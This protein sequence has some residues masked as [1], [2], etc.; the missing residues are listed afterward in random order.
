[1]TAFPP[2]GYCLL[3]LDL[4]GKIPNR[5][6][7]QKLKIGR[8]V[9]KERFRMC[10]NLPRGKASLKHLFNFLAFLLFLELKEF[11]LF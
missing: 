4:Q 10:R 8:N 5:T 6:S 2:G 1:M 7:H 9:S 3:L 11:F